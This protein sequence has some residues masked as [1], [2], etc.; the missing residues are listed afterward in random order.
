MT[1]PDLISILTVALLFDPVGSCTGDI[2]GDRRVDSLDLTTLLA[3]FGKEPARWTEG[4]VND[5]GRVD[6]SDLI[7]VVATWNCREF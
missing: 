1:Y 3:N 6:G 2:N 4:D 7:V 5:D